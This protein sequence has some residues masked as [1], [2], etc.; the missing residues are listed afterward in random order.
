M[1]D[2]VPVADHLLEHTLYG[3]PFRRLLEAIGLPVLPGLLL[4]TLQPLLGLS[5]PLVGSV[6]LGGVLVGLYVYRCTPDGQQPL[7]WML[8]RLRHALQPVRYVWDP[9][10]A[11]DRPVTATLPKQ[12]KWLTTDTDSTHPQTHD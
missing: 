7:A 3:F 12:D 10:T 5:F 11:T 2:P 1:R 4:Y 8:A 9:Q 6:G